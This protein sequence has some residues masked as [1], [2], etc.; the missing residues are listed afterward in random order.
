MR[1][2]ILM[3]T[4]AL[5]ALSTSPAFAQG[6]PAK[7]SDETATRLDE[8]V[9]TAQK[10]EENIQTV[11]LSIMSVSGE[12]L[13]RSGINDPTALQK[14]VPTLQINNTLFG[15][16][17]VI[18]IRG[19]GSAANT[20]VDSDVASYVDGAYVPR[21][22]ALLTS[23]LDVKNVEVLSGPQGTLFGRNAA[24][25]AISINTNAPS[26]TERSL[27]LTAEAGR[28][29]TVI[30]SAVINQ[31]FGEQFGVRLAIKGS[32]TGGMFKNLF[33]GKTYGDREGLVMRLSTKAVL[34][35]NLTWILRGDYTKT[36]GDGVYPGIVYTRTADPAALTALNAFVT[37]N[38]GKPLV[39]S[40]NPS[41]TINQFMPGPF[42][43]DRQYGVTSDLRW[44]VSSNI[45]L[46]LINNYRDWHNNQLAGDTVFTPLDLL[47]VNTVTNSKAQ[48]HELQLVSSK[49]AFMGGKLGLTAGLYYAREEFSI[50]TGFNLGSQ[51]CP[52]ILKLAGPATIGGCRAQPQTGSGSVA[53]AQIAK[54]YAAYLQADYQIAPSQSLALGVRH[55]WD[56]KD[57]SYQ[58]VRRN[59]ALAALLITD[60]APALTFRDEKTSVRASLSWNISDDVMAFATFSTGYKSGG[61]N[62]GGTAAVLSSAV[63]TFASETVKDYEAG[64][65]AK[66][67][68]GRARLNLTVFQTDLKNFQDRSF[69]GTSFI[70]RNS[71]NV[72]SRGLDMDGEMLLAPRFRV[73]F[74]GTYLDSIYTDNTSAP[75]LEGCTGLAGCPTVQNLTGKTLAFAPKLQGNIGAEW[76][77]QPFMNGI[78]LALAVNEHFTSNFLTANTLNEQSRVPGYAT[79]DLRLS[80]I[81]EGDKWRLDL[82]GENIFDKHYFVTTVAQTLG[83]AMGIN[84]NTTGTTVFRG[85]LGSPANFGARLS[86]NF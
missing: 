5:L 54:S 11:P 84:N 26:T 19:F 31:P 46:R 32:H 14:L 17:V 34:A 2:H 58:A 44:G 35:P 4:A 60:S 25:G 51:F 13:N 86:L 52:V 80:L 76:K 68:D 29:G 71:G 85:F 57:G 50:D 20:A 65:K 83:A 63:R 9:V 10:R 66:L 28:F 16:G 75:G 36:T 39:Y 33:D 72:R 64:V 45:D 77:S 62:S 21:P 24:M 67:F 73:T 37:N 43:K 59:F 78:S 81:A 47:S 3:S 22:G 12:A 18:R 23:F 41:Y 82:F 69:S 61:F 55:T 40:D 27:A 48:S 79:T 6:G 70:I 1:N 53:F 38:G 56:H 7:G 30:G 74:G 49:D 42:Q 15:S 8:I